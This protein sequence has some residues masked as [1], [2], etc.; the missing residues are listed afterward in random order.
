[1]AKWRGFL[2]RKEAEKL[3]R[4]GDSRRQGRGKSAERETVGGVEAGKA[5]IAAFSEQG[6][7]SYKKKKQKE[8]DE[9][10]EDEDEEDEEDEEEEEEEEELHFWSRF[11]SYL[12]F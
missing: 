6:R 1:M 9:E 4:D 5:A 12:C 10:D 11:S 8:E 7:H 2:Y 3:Q